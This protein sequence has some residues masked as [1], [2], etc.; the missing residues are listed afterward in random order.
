MRSKL[1]LSAI[2]VLVFVGSHLARKLLSEPPGGD[3]PEGR[4][5]PRIVSMAPSI[6]ET[7]FAL[8]LGDRVVG[9]TQYCDY[10]PEATTRTCVG[11][12]HNPNFEA[13]VA[14]KPDLV[15]MLDGSAASRRAFR[16]LGL[17]TLAVCHKQVEGILASIAELGR[18]CG[19]EQQATRILEDL[20]WRMRRIEQKTAQQPRPRVMVV[21]GRTLGSGGLED[22]YIAAGDGHLDRIVALAGGENA[23]RQGTVRFPVVSKE[24]VMYINPQVIVDLV[25]EE[26]VKKLGREAILADWQQLAEVEA[27]RTGRVYLIDHDR[28]TRPGPGFILLVEQLARRFHPRLDWQ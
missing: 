22:V 26:S 28:A 10:P 24:A 8:G 17:N 3:P 27:V 13:V 2:I 21:V 25:R 4:D 11:G 20:R 14:L 23:Y 18:R 15:V 16:K 5:C 6:T 19:A 1:L 12:Y 9:V 7:L